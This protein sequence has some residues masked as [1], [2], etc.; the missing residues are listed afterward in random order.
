MGGLPV[1][2][3]RRD[4]GSSQSQGA[5]SQPPPKPA[6]AKPQPS[7]IGATLSVE[8]TLTGEEDI[9][10]EGRFGGEIKLLKSRVVI[11]GT[12]EVTANVKAKTVTINGTAKGDVEAGDQV[13]ITATGSMKGDIRSP[14]VILHD[15]AKFRGRID[16]EPDGIEEEQAP[17]VRTPR[18]P[19]KGDKA[20]DQP[21]SLPGSKSDARAGG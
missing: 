17:N 15:G 10:I 9:E 1:F 11:G 8:G 6:V 20:G 18:P 21:A 16:M 7:V 13:E 12:G 5:A 19:S 4:S 2:D 14:R 3:K